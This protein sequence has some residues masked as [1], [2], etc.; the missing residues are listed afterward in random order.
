MVRSLTKVSDAESLVDLHERL[1]FLC[2]YPPNQKTLNQAE[3]DLKRI[4]ARV[5]RLREAD[6]DLSPLKTPEASG[7]AGMSVTS[8]FSYALVRWLVAKF[9]NQL[10]ID[11]EWFDRE[12][13][14]GATMRR[15][16]PLLEEDA[17]VEAHEPHR[18]WLDFARGP[19][20]E[21]QPFAIWH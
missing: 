1:L 2:A 6:E 14:F 5:E 21:V 7:I 18:K 10:S 3:K 17:M 12:D 19:Q 16:L 4:A 20:N 13:Q 11:W 9:P 15:F 8:N